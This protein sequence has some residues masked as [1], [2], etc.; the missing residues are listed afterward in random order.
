MAKKRVG[1]YPKEFRRMAVERLNRCENI[2]ALSNR[3]LKNGCNQKI[4]LA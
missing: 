3:L 1:R 2:V 4:P